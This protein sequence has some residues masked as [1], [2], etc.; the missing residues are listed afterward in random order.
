MPHH[1][2]NK[3]RHKIIAWSLFGSDSHF[4]LNLQNECSSMDFSQIWNYDRQIYF[5]Y[6]VLGLKCVETQLHK[7]ISKLPSHKTSTR[8]IFYPTWGQNS[9]TRLKDG[10]P[11]TSPDRGFH[12]MTKNRRETWQIVRLITASA[13][14]LRN[15]SRGHFT[16]SPMWALSHTYTVFPALGIL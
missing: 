6:G 1:F 4:V 9:K 11:T 12:H 3:R 15:S 8:N 7:E 2:K 13:T 5:A 16:T 10:I 14:R